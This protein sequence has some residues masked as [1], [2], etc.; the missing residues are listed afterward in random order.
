MFA[1][2]QIEGFVLILIGLLH[3]VGHDV[4]AD[5]EDDTVVDD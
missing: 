1:V 3:D 5:D 4:H 2:K